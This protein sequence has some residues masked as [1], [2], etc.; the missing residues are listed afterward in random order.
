MSEPKLLR[1]IALLQEIE[2][3]INSQSEQIARIDALVKS[4]P[5]DDS[6][7]L[8]DRAIGLVHQAKRA[9]HLTTE[10]AA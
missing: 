4:M 9:R 8:L 10:R 5:A 6:D 7:I 3:R 2:A 1:N